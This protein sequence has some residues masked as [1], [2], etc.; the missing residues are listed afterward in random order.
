MNRTKVLIVEDDARSLFALESVLQARG[1]AVTA[2]PTA[3]EAHRCNGHPY[4]VAVI[5]VRLPGQQGPDYARQLRN[6]HPDTRIIFV[7]AF[8]GVSELGSTI[9]GS[10]VLVKP[11]DVDTLVKL[12]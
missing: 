5:D 4:D 8:N 7:T 9:P 2:Y 10:I 1:F 3:E 11:I 6:K 12:L